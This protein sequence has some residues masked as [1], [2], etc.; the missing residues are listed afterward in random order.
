MKVSVLIATRN[1]EAPLLRCL[2]ILTEQ[3][4]P[5][6]FEIIVVDDAS[7]QLDVRSRVADE[8]GHRIVCYRT[9]SPRGVAGA[10]NLLIEKAAGDVLVFLDDDAFPTDRSAILRVKQHFDE[11]PRCGVLAFKI[12]DVQPGLDTLL[13]PF[14]RRA[15]RGN[16]RIAEEEGRVSYFVGAGHALRRDVVVRAG[17]YQDDF[18][19]GLEEL[20]LSYRAIQAGFEIHYSPSI[21]IEH[22]PEPSVLAQNSK[23]LDAELLYRV[24]NRFYLAKRYLPLPYPLTYLPV[25]LTKHA[26]DAVSRGAL[27]A[28]FRGIREGV[29]SFAA[30]PRTPLSPEAVAYLKEHHGR[31]W[32]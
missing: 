32:Y 10:R 1:R 9:P 28:Y 29:R 21:R 20:D 19:Y 26:I 13:V 3:E 5:E 24:K 23:R 16:P 15:L 12:H 18:V 30:V 6:G 11:H 17:T 31:L 4:M 7:D 8:F 14:S 27:R 2:R 22:R 25:W